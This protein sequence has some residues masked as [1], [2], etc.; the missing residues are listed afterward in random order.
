MAPMLRAARPPVRPFCAAVVPA[1]HEPDGKCWPD[2]G[3]GARSPDAATSRDPPA[4][5]TLGA[6][7][8]RRRPSNALVR[9]RATRFPDAAARRLAP[10]SAYVRRADGL[11]SSCSRFCYKC[12]RFENNRRAGSTSDSGHPSATVRI[13]TIPSGRRR[14]PFEQAQRRRLDDRRL[15]RICLLQRIA[16]RGRCIRSGQP[17]DR[18]A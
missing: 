9:G 11:E 2:N 17:H 12:S 1:R 13:R 4:N 6:A 18:G 5:A 8:P 10:R 14:L 15:R 3:L 16:R 7:S